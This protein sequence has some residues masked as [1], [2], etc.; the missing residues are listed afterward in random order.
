MCCAAAMW[1]TMHGASISSRTRWRVVGGFF[2]RVPGG[3]AIEKLNG[4]HF[5]MFTSSEV[6]VVE[7]A[8]DDDNAVWRNERNDPKVAVESGKWRA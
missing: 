7:Y 3:Y 2:S 6:E 1:G 8:A 5:G 4:L